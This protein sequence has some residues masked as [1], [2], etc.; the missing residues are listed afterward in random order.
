MYAQVENTKE[1]TSSADRQESRAVAN[2]VAL[3]K[4]AGKQSFGF[5]DNR[6]DAVTQSKMK[7]LEKR[8]LMKINMGEKGGVQ[9]EY[10]IF[11]L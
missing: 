10:V 6:R 8:T 4:Y 1:N 5:V 7:E 3:K 2:S 11:F 9:I